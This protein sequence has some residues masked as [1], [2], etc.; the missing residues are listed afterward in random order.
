MGQEVTQ[1][2]F[3]FPFYDTEC[4]YG[5][6]YETQKATG[7]VWHT[8]TVL[9]RSVEIPDSDP[10][11][12]MTFYFDLS[13]CFLPGETYNCTEGADCSFNIAED[14]ASLFTQEI[15]AYMTS[16]SAY[17]YL[18]LLCC[19]ALLYLVLMVFILIIIKKQILTP[20]KLLIEQIKNPK[21]LQQPLR[22]ESF[23]PFLREREPS[24]DHSSM[25]LAHRARMSLYSRKP[26]KP[27][28]NKQTPHT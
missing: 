26:K 18:I 5:N 9:S 20:I 27:T 10:R 2:S 15:N 7:Q 3:Y 4:T 8:N 28:E 16:R 13:G 23:R 6:K 22:S 25:P 1:V 11:V 12:L 17:N 14:D 21:G 24:L 19:Y